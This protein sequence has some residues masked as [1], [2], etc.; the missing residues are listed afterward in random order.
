MK[1][2]KKDPKMDNEDER[3]ILQTIF[4]RKRF[5]YTLKDVWHYLFTC[6]FCRKSRN[7][8]KDPEY[9][10]HVLFEKGCSKL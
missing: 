3:M 10:R 2:R 7:L 6:A 1:F 5:K 9:R 4:N 8:A